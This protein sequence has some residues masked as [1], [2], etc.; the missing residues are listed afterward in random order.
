MFDQIIALG[1]KK[2]ITYMES[3]PD[4]KIRLSLADANK[5]VEEKL[6]QKGIKVELDFDI[7]KSQFTITKDHI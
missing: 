4:N 5:W 3:Q 7:E 6:K 2:L 1:F